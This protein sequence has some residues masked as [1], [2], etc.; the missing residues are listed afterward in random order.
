MAVKELERKLWS[1]EKSGSLETAS[2]GKAA[3]SGEIY[4]GQRP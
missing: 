4:L 2:G 1:R 3:S